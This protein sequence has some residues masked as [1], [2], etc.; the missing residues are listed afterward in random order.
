VLVVR[1]GA[2]RVRMV[3]G[4]VAM[5][6]AVLPLGHRVMGVIVVVAIV[7]AMGMLMFDDLVVVRVPMLLGQ[8]EVGT[9]GHQR[10]RTDAG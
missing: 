5:P 8:V 9:E 4:L 10:A 6:V 2:M 7:V 1:V 3:T